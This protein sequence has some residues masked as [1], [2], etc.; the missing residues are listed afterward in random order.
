MFG[1]IKLAI[2]NVFR[3]K[4]RSLI[5]AVAIIFGIVILITAT[6]YVEGLYNGMT[7]TVIKSGIGHMQVHNKGYVQEMEDR[8]SSHNDYF[9]EKK[10]NKII[11]TP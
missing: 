9:N 1:L 2:K 7:D 6:S 10:V 5:Q 3:N 11:A 8:T 4:R